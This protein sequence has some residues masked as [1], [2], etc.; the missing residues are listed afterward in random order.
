MQLLFAIACIV[1][2]QMFYSSQQMRIYT[3]HGIHTLPNKEYAAQQDMRQD[4]IVL[5]FTSI[6]A[7]AQGQKSAN[8]FIVKAY[9]KISED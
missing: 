9:V 6:C 5:F 7:Q 2:F 4:N 8:P 1:L 3:Y